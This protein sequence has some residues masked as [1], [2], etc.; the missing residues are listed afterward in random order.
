MRILAVDY[1]DKRVGLAS[2]DSANK[3]AFPKQLIENR[4]DEGVLKDL[5]GI[6][7]SE[8]YEVVVF[9]L[10]YDMD[11]GKGEQ[12]GKVEAFVDKFM[13]QV[14]ISNFDIKVEVIDEALS[15]FEADEYLDDFKGKKVR[16]KDGDRDVLA[17]KVILDR[18]FTGST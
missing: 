2:G 9:G 18:Y 13:E 15:S 4:G 7:N 12:Y 6:C 11:G 5:L 17:A 3:I 10:P 16:K 1:G 14:S 8:G